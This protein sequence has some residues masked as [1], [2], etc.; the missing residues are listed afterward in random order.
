MRRVTDRRLQLKQKQ[1]QNEGRER[2]RTDEKER[3]FREIQ[4][5]AQ[6]NLQRIVGG[7]YA[8]NASGTDGAGSD[9]KWGNCAG[10]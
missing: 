7:S 9:G 6:K 4:S 8:G 1:K 5:D 2:K 3:Y 10:N